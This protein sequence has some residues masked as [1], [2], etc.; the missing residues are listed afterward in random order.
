ME[1]YSIL[2]LEREPFSNSPD[3]AFFFRSGQHTNCLQKL[4]IAVRLKRGLSLVIGRVGT[5][6]TTLCRQLVRNMADEE[7]TEVHLILDP[8]FDTPRDMLAALEGML[9]DTPPD[10]AATP[11]QLKERIQGHLFK[12]GVDENKLVVLIVDEGQKL[13]SE[14]LEVLRELLNYETN[15]HK[16]LQIVIFAQTEIDDLIAGHENFADRINLTLRLGPL[17]LADTREMILYRMTQARRHR[18]DV[19]AVNF[20]RGAFKAIHKATGGYPRK[21]IHLCHKLLLQLII[22][23]CSKVDAALVRLVAS[24]REAPRRGP[25]RRL[26][27]AASVLL[28][29]GLGGG[30]AAMQVTGT[31]LPALAK[32]LPPEVVRHLPA[33]T[34]SP[35]HIVREPVT[36]PQAPIEEIIAPTSSTPTTPAASLGTSVDTILAVPAAGPAPSAA[37]ALPAARTES[38]ITPRPGTAAKTA[39]LSKTYD[40]PK[41]LGSVRVRAGEWVWRMA[42]R[43]YGDCNPDI[44][45]RVKRAN[46]DAGNWDRMPVGTRIRFPFLR[47]PGGQPESGH[48]LRLAEY[49]SLEQAYDALRRNGSDSVRLRAYMTPDGVLGFGL[50]ARQSFDTEA[51]ALAYL[52][53][54]PGDS[55][56]QA[57]VFDTAREQTTFLSRLR[58][59]SPRAAS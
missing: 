43:I 2:D 45:E 16:L 47:T 38:V 13:S 41:Y 25:A 1:Y 58:Q 54:L 46:P 22:Q 30:F 24:G 57:R 33:L 52:D 48:L 34:A 7:H 14:S 42:E 29:L 32:A 5:G 19:P 10:K 23:N 9:A 31:T 15:E 3:P 21:I 37:C 53:K 40:M 39:P 27:L 56:T 44:L 59:N 8:A 17:D 49:P 55:R 35:A 6:K 36:Q 28:A 26:A 20:T 50:F 12:K 11:G 18:P 51:D 4:E